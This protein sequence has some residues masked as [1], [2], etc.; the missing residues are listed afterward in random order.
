MKAK[1][2]IKCILVLV[3]APVFICGA[4]RIIP[5]LNLDKNPVYSA[6]NV[7]SVVS[8]VAKNYSDTV[9]GYKNRDIVASGTV[10]EI[11][12]N[13]KSLSVKFGNDTVTVNTKQKDDV[14]KLSVGDD[15]TVYGMFDIGSEKKKTI[16]IKADHVVKGKNSLDKDYYIYDGESYSDKD[17]ELVSIDG[18]RIKFLIP[19]SWKN[20]EVSSEAYQKIF[21]SNISSTNTG[22]C[23]YINIAKGQKEPEV[24]CAFF[25][26]DNK[27][28][29]DSMD[30]KDLHGKE[31]AI[32]TNICPNENILLALP[33]EKSTTSNGLEIE[34]YVAK[35]DNYRIEFA[36]VPVKDGLAVLMHM[37]DDDSV[38]VDDILYLLNSLSVEK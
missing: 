31:K 7:S 2:K 26:N 13:N 4:G 37:Y 36:F 15:I 21:N 3:L 27:F 8:D 35:Y 18:E 30:S 12:K 19:G 10:Q 34:H 33:V 29:E 11:G 5:K 20:T 16:S 25:F 14:A 23:Y 24:F 32:V 17:S 1:T 22:K 38:R 28:L 6:C 9:D